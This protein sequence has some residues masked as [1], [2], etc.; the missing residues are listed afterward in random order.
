MLEPPRLRRRWIAAST[1]AGTDFRAWSPSRV[2]LAVA[3]TGAVSQGL[4]PVAYVIALH[5][6]F[7]D[8]RTRR[9]LVGDDRGTSR[10]TARPSPRTVHRSLLLRRP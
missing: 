1:W 7:V 5:A 9:F 6:T 8:C 4:R 10:E 2:D 3:D